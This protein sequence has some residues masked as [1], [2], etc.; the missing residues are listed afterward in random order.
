M[1]SFVLR[2]LACNAGIIASY[3]LETLKVS[4]QTNKE[5]KMMAGIE[6]PVIFSSFTNGIRFHIFNTLNPYSYVFALILAGTVNG[7]LEY[8]YQT[9]KLKLQL[10][11]TKLFPGGQSIIFFKELFGTILHFYLYGLLTHEYSSDLEI[12]LYGG[13]SAAIGM[14]IVYPY[15]TI[16]VNYKTNN[17]P[18]MVTIQNKHLWKGYFY[19]LLRTF[20]GYGVTMLFQSKII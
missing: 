15:D 11:Q 6:A 16:F 12:C 1:Q 8:P 18:P 2:C 17:T 14:T 13:L 9:T 20:V 7:I 10:N 5:V 19:N 3:P 4:Q